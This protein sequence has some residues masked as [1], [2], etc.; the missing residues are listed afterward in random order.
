MKIIYA[1]E[2]LGFDF[3]RAQPAIFLAGP[4]PRSADVPSWRPEALQLL[5]EMKYNGIVYVPESRSKSCEGG[6][7]G[8]AEYDLQVE[9]ETEALEAASCIL[10]WIP[11]DLVTMP[12]FTTND[13]WGFWK[14]SGKCVLGIPRDAPKTRYQAWWAD[15]L[16]VPCFNNLSDTVARSILMAQEQYGI[17]QVDWDAS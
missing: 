15:R 9:W 12:G 10:F 7:W 6:A 3:D 17:A 13:E 4:T 16:E 11:R 14:A 1:S 2:E 5:E 8:D